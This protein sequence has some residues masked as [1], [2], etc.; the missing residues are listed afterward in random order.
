MHWRS[1]LWI[2]TIPY[3]GVILTTNAIQVS[4]YYMKYIPPNPNAKKQ[5]IA[6]PRAIINAKQR[7]QRMVRIGMSQSR[8]NLTDVQNGI[9]NIGLD[10]LHDEEFEHDEGKM[11][12]M[13]S[14]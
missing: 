2:Q 7:S 8:C 1:C 9:A 6:N 3:K 4:V 11:N 5:V 13:C 12:H 14:I 10:I